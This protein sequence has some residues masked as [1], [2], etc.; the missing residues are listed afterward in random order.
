MFASDR[1]AWSNPDPCDEGGELRGVRTLFPVILIVASACSGGS[2]DPSSESDKSD[3][4]SSAF[5]VTDALQA[6]GPLLGVAFT[7]HVDPENPTVRPTLGFTTKDTEV[8]AVIGI[9]DVE[10]GSTLVVTWYRIAGPDEREALFSHEIIVG[11]GDRA[12]SQAVAPTGLAPGIYDTEAT[13]DGH[14]THT[15]WVVREAGGSQTGATAQAASAKGAGDVPESG[16][17][18]DEINWPQPP[19]VSKTTC[20]V[21]GIYG[22]MVFPSRN[23]RGSATWLGPCTTGTLTATVSGPPTTL[24]S[25]DSLQEQ[26]LGVVNM[27]GEADVCSLAGGS[28]LPGT[29]VHLEATGSASGSEDF[30]LPDLSGLLVAGL[31]GLPVPESE[32]QPGDRIDLAAFAILDDPALGV[33]TLY[34]DD[35]NELVE[36]VGNASGSDQPVPCDSNRLLAGIQ[37]TYEVPSDPPPVIELC[38][39]GVGFDGTKSKYCI[40]YYTGE[41]WTG[42]GT[43]TS[44]ATYPDG[45]TCR[46]AVKI[47]YTIGVAEDG[48]IEGAGVATH[49]EEAVCPFPTPGAQWETSTLSV[50]GHRDGQNLSLT[51]GSGSY[52]PAGG[53]DYGGFGASLALGAGTVVLTVQGTSAEGT[54]AF[55]ESS[56][57]PPA[58]YSASGPVTVSCTSGCG[59]G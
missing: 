9:G 16:D 49:T 55:S 28:D 21:D 58:V 3:K 43:F 10:E 32:V 26:D 38:A 34:V 54:A 52:E 59:S 14:V 8:T 45:S 11:P 33:K 23:V 2:S 40:R 18:Y 41:V 25:S 36:S 30:T 5:N 29:V 37:T 27:D 56:G 44:S 12:F 57:N 15:P 1:R 53:I 47:E 31:I 35:G 20:T 19:G 48:A 4:V 6:D 42:S 51:F 13:M 24:A 17:S 46:D 7:G 39:T 50:S 22:E